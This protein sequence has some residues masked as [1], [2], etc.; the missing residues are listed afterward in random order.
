MGEVELGRGWLEFWRG[1][2]GERMA[3]ILLTAETQRRRGSEFWVWFVMER[4]DGG[5]VSF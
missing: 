5:L 1:G 4:Y 3:G 2:V